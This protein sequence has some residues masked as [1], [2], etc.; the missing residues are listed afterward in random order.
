VIGRQEALRLGL[1]VREI[2]SRISTGRW[3]RRTPGVYRLAGSPPSPLADLRA[4][5]V[6]GGAGAAAS[7]MSAAW[8]WGLADDP[9]EPTVTIPHVRVARVGGVRVVRSRIPV[10]VV[11]RR[12]IPCTDPV[13]TILDCAAETGPGEI[14]DLTDRALARRAFRT[15]DLVWAVEVHPVLRQ[16]PA[17]AKL[18]ARLAVRGVTGAPAPS[19]LESRTARLLC[20]AG[21]PAPTAELAWG[22]QRRYRLD[23][24]Y[25]AVKLVVEVDGHAFHFTPEQQRWD[26]RRQNA[27]VSAGWTVLRYN[28]WDV[29]YDPRRVGAEIAAAYRA[30]AA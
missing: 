20:A 29:T 24:A 28:W 7:H 2:D 5:V 10:R 18:A 22:P 13:R 21:L 19:V 23:F 12:A 17:R 25:P 14:D 16:H 9:P 30:L 27:L 26:N 1:T 3:V 8:L 4:A 6:G 15:D 11:V